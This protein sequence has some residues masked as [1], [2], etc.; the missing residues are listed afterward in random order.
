MGCGSSN[1]PN[2]DVALSQED[3]D[4]LKELNNADSQLELSKTKFLSSKKI[5]DK[6]IREA[7]EA[8]KN[9]ELAKKS[10]TKEQIE[11][12]EASIRQ[13]E[14]EEKSIKE[15]DEADEAR[16]VYENALIALES[17]PN[18]EEKKIALTLAKTSL[19]KETL[20]S[21]EANREL[22]IAKQ[23]AEKEKQEAE[24]AA[25]NFIKASEIADKE[26]KEAIEASRI[27]KNIRGEVQSNETIV[28]LAEIAAKVPNKAGGYMHK[29]GSLNPGLKKRFFVL[30]RGILTYYKEETEKKSNIGKTMCGEPIKLVNYSVSSPSKNRIVLICNDLASTSKQRLEL[31]L[32]NFTQ[33]EQW[34]LSFANHIQWITA[35]DKIKS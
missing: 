21:V 10:Q 20:E 2:E 24:E 35:A 17:D 29:K 16:F 13:K 31:E 7:E 1:L 26:R 3:I 15:K 18:N 25:L 30:D 27:A 11:A 34:T 6:E 19:D 32:S 4:K 22:Q 8:E 9:L 12:D 33:V 14:A 5:E 28:G 23:N